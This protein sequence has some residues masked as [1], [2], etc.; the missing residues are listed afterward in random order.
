M[1]AK[2]TNVAAVAAVV[3]ERSP[4]RPEIDIADLKTIVDAGP[5]GLFTPV[6]VHAGL[7]EAGLVEINAAFVDEHGMIATRATAAGVAR[8]KAKDISGIKIEDNM[9]IPATALRGRT[10]KSKLPFDLMEVG[11]SFFV[12]ATE[13]KPEPAK[14]LASQVS[15]I[16]K[17]YAYPDPTG[18]TKADKKGNQTPVIIKTRNFIVREVIENG[19][20]GARVW[21]L[22]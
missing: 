7:V 22:S 10:S 1:A 8:I 12:A 13:A 20:T 19:V 9:P 3:E 21:R 4:D 16:V 2:K 11:Q 5:N 6:A 17:S 14:S 15:R 18:A